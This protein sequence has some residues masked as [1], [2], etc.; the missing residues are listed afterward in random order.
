MLL[1]TLAFLLECMEKQLKR[2]AMPESTRISLRRN[3]PARKCGW[4]SIKLWLVLRKMQ[5][6]D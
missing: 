2:R 6:D 3:S 1:I 5:N 4:P